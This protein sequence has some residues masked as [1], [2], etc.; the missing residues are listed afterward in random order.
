MVGIAYAVGL[1]RAGG[2]LLAHGSLATGGGKWGDCGTESPPDSSLGTRCT[3]SLLILL[4]SCI[5]LHHND[6]RPL[7]FLAS[8]TTLQHR[9][10][11]ATAAHPHDSACHKAHRSAFPSAVRLST[12][13]RC[14]YLIA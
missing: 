12:S 10:S 1:M 3:S 7:P 11:L 6:I 14:I 8:L 4:A 9:T 13:L 2:G 5:F